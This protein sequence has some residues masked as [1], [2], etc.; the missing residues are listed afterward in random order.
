MTIAKGRCESDPMPWESAAGGRP[1]V[2]TNMVIIMGRSLSTA[3]S[4]ADSSKAFFCSTMNAAP[5][6]QRLK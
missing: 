3:P 2:A 6:T 5:N 4:T 1:S